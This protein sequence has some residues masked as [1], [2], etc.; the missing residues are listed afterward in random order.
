MFLAGQVGPAAEEA[1]GKDVPVVMTAP[2]A[3]PEVVPV[4]VCETCVV[5]VSKAGA[6][7]SARELQDSLS[8]SK[9]GGPGGSPAAEPGETA[10]Q[11]ARRILREQR[12]TK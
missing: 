5:Q 10:E 4:A 11:M 9:N 8:A 6:G 12:P 2:V 3:V 1:A 7:S